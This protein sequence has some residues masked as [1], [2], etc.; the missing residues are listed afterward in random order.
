[1]LFRSYLLARGVT[2]DPEPYA[3]YLAWQD[4]ERRRAAH[5]PG[6]IISCSGDWATG[7][8]GVDSVTTADGRT[9]LV[10]DASYEAIHSQPGALLL[11][12]GCRIVLPG[13]TLPEPQPCSAACP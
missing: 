7:Q 10:T 6:L 13:D 11:L 4:Y 3:Q 9:H 1:V 5:D 8:P 12:S 2:P